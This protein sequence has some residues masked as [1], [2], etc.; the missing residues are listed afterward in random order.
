[1]GISF[2]SIILFNFM[3]FEVVTTFAGDMQNP[4]RKFPRQ[5]LWAVS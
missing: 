5:S 1:M 3:G 4:K 2:I